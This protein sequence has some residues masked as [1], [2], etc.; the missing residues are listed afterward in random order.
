[1]TYKEL[2]DNEISEKI[3]ALG[4]L[5]AGSDEHKATV[6]ELTKLMDRSIELEK[7]EVNVAEK[8]KDREQ[9]KLD[10]ELKKEQLANDQKDRKFGRWT[11]VISIVVPV[12]VAIWGTLYT[13][14]WEKTDTL[15]STAGKEHSRNLFKFFTKK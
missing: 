15:T 8:A 5:E 13:T 7:L 12:G 14:K 1:M 3:E 9:A 10:T 11:S 4:V 6:D 2:L